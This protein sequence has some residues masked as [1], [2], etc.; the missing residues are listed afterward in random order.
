MKQW[1]RSF[2]NYSD[3]P[4]GHP[5]SLSRYIGI[6]LTAD[7]SVICDSHMRSLRWNPMLG[8]WVIVA[9]ERADRPFQDPGNSCP[10][11]SDKEETSGV[12]STLVL[13]NKYPALDPSVGI[14]PLDER[15]VM[16]AP[17]HG[18][19][20]VIV[21]TPHHN[22]QF[23]V[24]KRNQVLEVMTE[25][26]NV[27][28]ELDQKQG[29]SYVMQFENRGRAIGVSLDHPHAQ[30]YALPFIPARI[31]R[32]AEQGLRKWE[33]DG[34]CLVCEIIENETKSETSRIIKETK[35]YISVVPFA[36]RLPYE[37]HVYPK[38]HTASFNDIEGSLLEFGLVLQDVVKRYAKI[39]DEM[40]YVLAFHTRP[41]QGEYPFWH[42][43]AEFYPPWRD[44]SRIK[45]LAGIET[46]AE[47]Y[48]ND[49]LPERIAEELREAL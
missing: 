1:Q 28:R 16:E 43:H 30:V 45:Y 27:F 6:D 3:G 12:W 22:E 36:A 17:A 19:C 10:F 9:P 8:E 38:R 35:N 44:S 18:Y 42:F 32:E 46:G 15:L 14:V 40:A 21:L 2:R 11:C 23:E 5:S 48:T 37:V 24:M 31:R 25:Y 20:K 4:S 29:I 33:E 13:D 41:S 47:A 26:R 34:K 49:S 39:F 7:S